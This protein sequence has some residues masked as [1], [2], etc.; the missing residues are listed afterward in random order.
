MLIVSNGTYFFGVQLC[1]EISIF[2]VFCEICYIYHPT[3]G[4]SLAIVTVRATAVLH[5]AVDVT[6]NKG[7][8]LWHCC[9]KAML[10]SER[11][12]R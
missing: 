8:K 7:T 4:N 11:E 5:M 12:R 6:Q 3:L 1:I 2:S 10:N 9:I